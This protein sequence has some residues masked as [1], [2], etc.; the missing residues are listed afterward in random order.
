M[1]YGMSRAV[2][3]VVIRRIS[4]TADLR[5]L[6]VHPWHVANSHLCQ[7]NFEGIEQAC[8]AGGGVQ[9]VQPPQSVKYDGAVRN[10][11]THGAQ[12]VLQETARR[13]QNKNCEAVPFPGG[14]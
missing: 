7:V 6:G 9:I 14:I 13:S 11:S 3:C 4:K 1:P 12:L 5:S 8:V 2:C 10:G